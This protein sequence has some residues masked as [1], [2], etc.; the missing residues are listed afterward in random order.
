MPTLVTI[1]NIGRRAEKIDGNTIAVG[2]TLVVDLDDPQVRKE[3]RQDIDY[4]VLPD[5]SGPGRVVASDSSNTTLQVYDVLGELSMNIT[6]PADDALNYLLTV[7]LNQVTFLP[8]TGNIMVA[9]LYLL[10]DGFI[11]DQVGWSTAIVD[12]P[13]NLPIV[14]VFE[15]PSSDSAH[16]YTIGL[17]TGDVS[18]AVVVSSNNELQTMKLEIAA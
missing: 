9:D 17:S 2:D 12:N 4:I 1:K 16:Q 15:I 5:S 13:M 10:E 3:L 7:N 11:I 18:D 14:V 8:D 6:H